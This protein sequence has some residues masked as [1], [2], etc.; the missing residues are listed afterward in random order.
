M[1]H[2][3]ISF[4]LASSTFFSACTYTPFNDGVAHRV[5]QDYTATGQV[6]GTQAYI[7]GNHTVLEF[8]KPPAFLSVTDEKGNAVEYERLGRYYRLNHRLDTFTTVVNGRS[9]TFTGEPTT[10]THVFSAPIPAPL[11]SSPGK[12]VKLISTETTPVSYKN[13]AINALYS[14][15]KKQLGVIRLT[16]ET[17]SKNSK[18]KRDHLA[19]INTRLNDIESKLNKYASAIIFVTF[20]RYSTV[21]NPDREV[22]T[23]MIQSAKIADHIHISGYTDARIA[24]PRDAKI[25][26]S[27]ALAARNFLVDNGVVAE[28]IN[29]ISQ[30][31][32]GG[33]A[34]NLTKGRALNRRVEIE[35][36]GSH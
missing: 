30:A 8:D 5:S 21:F 15:A 3:S 20:P 7:Y 34:P 29:I 1:K 10:Q 13:A 36:F 32:G 12:A 23:V 35:F 6:E 16:L 18:T 22:V 2:V 28:K 14:L 27:R 33:I 25:A 11:I 26:L 9:I 4:F 31:D 17:V 19:E 24:G